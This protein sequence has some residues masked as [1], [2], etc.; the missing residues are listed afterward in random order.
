MPPPSRLPLFRLNT[1]GK[2][3]AVEENAR[4]LQEHGWCQAL[5]Q[6]KMMGPRVRQEDGPP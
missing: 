4:G 3:C 5:L 6:Y 1:P 2:H